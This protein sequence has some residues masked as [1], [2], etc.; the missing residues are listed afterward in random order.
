MSAGWT[1]LGAITAARVALA[2]EPSTVAKSTT[3]TSV[4]T[5]VTEWVIDSVIARSREILATGATHLCSTVGGA[6]DIAVVD[7]GAVVDTTRRTYGE[8]TI[9][10]ITAKIHSLATNQ[11]NPVPK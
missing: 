1:Q 10:T 7:E 2:S 11:Y 6:P 4:V 5:I 3:P 8:S 9:T